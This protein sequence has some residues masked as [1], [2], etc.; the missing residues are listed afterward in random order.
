VI[1]TVSLPSHAVP[2]FA[3]QTG[4]AC[5]SCHFQN[6]PSLDAFGRAFRANGY[7]VRGMQDVIEGDRLSLP[8][9]LNVSLIT[10]IRYEMKSD[11]DGRR[12]EI[13]WPDEAALLVGGRAAERVGF[14]AEVSVAP[15]AGEADV[16]NVDFNDTN[17]NGVVDASE[18][19]IQNGNG[20]VKT[21]GNILSYKVHFDVTDN[22]GII[23]FS[24]D[25][26]GAPFSF[27][28]MNTGMQRSLRPIENRKGMSAAQGLGLDGAA[29]GVAF[30]Y[31][32][33][34]FYLNYAHWLPTS[35]NVNADVFGGLAHYL[36][37]AYMPN[38]S[39][40]DTGVGGALWSG[41][42]DIGATDATKETLKVDAWAID[43]QTQGSLNNGWTLGVYGSYG[44]APKTNGSVANQ[45]NASTTDDK[46]A[47]AVMAKLGVREWR[48]Y[49]AYA[50]LDQNGQTEAQTTVGLQ[51]N[52]VQ[53]INLEL[54]SV[55]SEAENGD[56]WML[57]MFA[58]L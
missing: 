22:F 20:D 16:T 8:T 15:G 23:P 54:F 51:Y 2:A 46:R 45:Y 38:I 35:G 12:G 11:T 47:Y 37:A 49:L 17:G 48:P 28:P 6:F 7:T 4:M 18:L 52:V 9:N 58:A 24:T 3:R 30:V 36:R 29:T 25:A 31:S 55:S 41:E 13:Q 21:D 26:L 19:S 32:S 56:Y 44:T 40:W 27:E 43:A 33:E 10:K 53:N 57:M 42:V 1:T 34:K 39:G 14:L 50:S 5:A